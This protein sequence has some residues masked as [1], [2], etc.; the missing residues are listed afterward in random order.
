MNPKEIKERLTA[1]E[2]ST[3]DN[4]QAIQEIR[5]ELEKPSVDWCV[6]M[7]VE[8]KDG[9]KG[10]IVSSYNDGDYDIR[11]TND[12][13]RWDRYTTEELNRE[14]KPI[15]YPYQ[16]FLKV[17]DRVEWNGRKGTIIKIDGTVTPIKVLFDESIGLSSWYEIQQ[18]TKI[19]EAQNG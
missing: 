18:L 6:N 5:K 13:G 1:I 14:W 12:C 15:P 4:E 9:V 2:K 10:Y 11:Y 17:G 3:K 19:G 16:E 8:N 7:W